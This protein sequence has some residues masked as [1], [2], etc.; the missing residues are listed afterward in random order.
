M[1]STFIENFVYWSDISNLGPLLGSIALLK[2]MISIIPI[3]FYISAVKDIPV[4]STE[5]ASLK[6]LSK[7]MASSFA[8]ILNLGRS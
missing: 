7:I 1:Q 4:L 5:A 8:A 2:D 6:W 3:G